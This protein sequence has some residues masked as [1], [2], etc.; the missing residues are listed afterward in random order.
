MFKFDLEFKSS[1]FGEEMYYVEYLWSQIIFE[2]KQKV[3][4]LNLR[5]HVHALLYKAYAWHPAAT[6]WQHT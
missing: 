4:T 3:I 2:L 6:W 5:K 1:C